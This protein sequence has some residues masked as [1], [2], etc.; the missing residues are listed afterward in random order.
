MLAGDMSTNRS[1]SREETRF[2]IAKILREPNKRAHVWGILN[3]RKIIQ[4]GS[5]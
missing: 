3:D 2:S 5:V 4:K 1:K